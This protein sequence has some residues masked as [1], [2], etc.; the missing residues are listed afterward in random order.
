MKLLLWLLAIG[1]TALV[2]SWLRA[3]AGEAGSPLGKEP[4]Q[5]VAPPVK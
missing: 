3:P 1:A 2:I 4:A 5:Q